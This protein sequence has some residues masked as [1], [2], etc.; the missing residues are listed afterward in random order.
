MLLVSA[1]S[2]KIVIAIK[3]TTQTCAWIFIQEIPVEKTQ[4]L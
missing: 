4:L 2:G 1:I 3:H